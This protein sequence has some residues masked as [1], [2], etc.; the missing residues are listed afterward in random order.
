M[1]GEPLKIIAGSPDK[2]LHLG[3]MEIPCY[4]L[5]NEE[6]V[7]AQRGVL[8]GLQVSRGTGGGAGDRLSDF[9]NGKRISPY[10]SNEL[11]LVISA[12]IVFENPLG[13][14]V[15]HG[16]PATI[17]ADICETLL[18]ARQAGAL[19]ARQLRIAEH[20]E[21]LV[22]GMTRVGIIGLVDEATGYQE[23]RAKRALADILEEYLAKQLQPW[24]QTF[25]EDFYK[26]MFRLRGW[27]Y[28]ALARGERPKRPGVVGR[29]TV[30]LVYQRIAPGVWEELEHL[31]PTQDDGRRKNK[32]H[33]WFTPDFGHPKLKEHLAGVMALM[34][35]SAN[36][37]QF[38]RNVNRAYPKQEQQWDLPLPE[39][40]EDDE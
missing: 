20:C 30:D 38:I 31:E 1:S 23:I 17:L 26:E 29:Y 36:W 14:G 12:P 33:Q 40:D 39:D 6:R 19:E 35:A 22:R 9:L 16:Y 25:S 37:G 27:S 7:L 21:M 2:P 15:I 32:L 3:G 28:A 18:K 11:R 10:V 4:V 34:R 13:G 5:E 24:T 8:E